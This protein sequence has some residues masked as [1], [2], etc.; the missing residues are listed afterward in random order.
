M[1]ITQSQYWNQCNAIKV[2]TI[3]SMFNV[4]SKLYQSGISGA[5]A[6]QIGEQGGERKKLKPFWE[7][8][9]PCDT[10]NIFYCQPTYC[11]DILIKK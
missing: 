8:V 6:W 5:L 2:D 9:P 11:A 3:I 4:T 10:N 7:K 1:Y